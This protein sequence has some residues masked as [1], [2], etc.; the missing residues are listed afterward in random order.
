MNKTAVI[1]GAGRGIGR[2]IAFQLAINGYNIA[3][4]YVGGEDMVT[5]ALSSI[6]STGVTVRAY[7]CDVADSTAVKSTAERVIADFG[8]VDVL[9]NNAG[10]TRDNLVLRM[11]EDDFDAVVNVNL[12]GTFNC[13]KQFMRALMKSTQGRIINIAS[14]SGIAGNAGQANY[15]AA[16]AGVQAL[17]K[18]LAREL[19]GKNVTVNAI[20][21]GYI[22]T[23]MTAT[24]PEEVKADVLSRVPLKRMGT[25]SDIAAAAI[26]LASDSASYITGQTIVVDGGLTM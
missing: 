2:E 13:C 26:F 11:P 12:R 15:A 23:D 5:D 18:V 1:T 9:V 14:V 3:I 24:L 19:A 4:L 22:N 20:A 21:P 7:P 17:T 8:G 25:T 10:I 16:K 6:K